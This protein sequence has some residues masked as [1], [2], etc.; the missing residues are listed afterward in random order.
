[1]S[2]TRS[3][4]FSDRAA[5]AGS[6]SPFMTDPSP[7]ARKRRSSARQRSTTSARARAISSCLRLLANMPP[8]D[9][10]Q[11]T[12]RCTRC[13]ASDCANAVKRSRRA[14]VPMCDRSKLR[15]C[16]G[17]LA[18]PRATKR[19]KK[20]S[21]NFAVIALSAMYSDNSA[22][23]W[24]AGL[25]SSEVRFAARCSRPS[26]RASTATSGS[27][28]LAR[29]SLSSPAHCAAAL[30]QGSQPVW[31]SAKRFCER[32]T[33]LSD[34]FS[35]AE[36]LAAPRTVRMCSW[37]LQASSVSS[38]T[39]PASHSAKASV[40]FEPRSQREQSRWTRVRRHRVARPKPRGRITPQPRH[41][42]LRSRGADSALCE[43]RL[44]RPRDPSAFSET[45][46]SVSDGQQPFASGRSRRA[47]VKPTP[48]RR[49]VATF[50]ASRAQTSARDASPVSC[51]AVAAPGATPR[52]RPSSTT[53]SKCEVT[54][55]ARA[56]AGRSSQVKRC[57]SAVWS[58]HATPKL[59]SR[60]PRSSG[61]LAARFW[62][63][64]DSTHDR[65][66]TPK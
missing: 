66:L 53:A 37:Q 6:K 1:M 4:L 26:N 16:S 31:S 27:S 40:P 33:T 24:P 52:D 55:K 36:L 60:E 28:H 15:S 41:S 14:S 9:A 32:S 46:S 56:M 42:S 34:D 3:V 50:D 11:Q 43:A 8:F 22:T 64:Y 17:G 35:A 38:A 58:R 51:A 30:R 54:A 62:K 13:G 21:P 20:T 47:A 49:T 18:T 19:L 57:L 45:S 29:A 61:F 23:V 5:S 63:R 48:T 7:P 10:A 39:A 2:R 25:A 59:N 65:G 12:L 44:R